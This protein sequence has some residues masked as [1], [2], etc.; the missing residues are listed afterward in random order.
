M[1]KTKIAAVALCLGL[2]STAFSQSTKADER[3][4][5]TVVSFSEPVEIPGSLLPPGTYVFKLA[6]S[7]SDRHIVQ[8]FSADERHVYATLLAIP[9]ER[10]EPTGKTAITFEER[11]KDTPEAIKAWFYPGDN[12]GQRFVYHKI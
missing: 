5:K 8:I 10:L 2:L 1:R 9:D 3:D 6:N 12:V 7:D 11:A 4:K